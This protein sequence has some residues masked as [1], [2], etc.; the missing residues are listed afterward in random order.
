[1]R[2]HK[3]VIICIL[4]I[5]NVAFAQK[6]NIDFYPQITKYDLAKIWMPE[7]VI[8]DERTREKYSHNLVS[9]NLKNYQKRICQLL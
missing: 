3:I 4:F 8:H 7:S 5:I 1:M 6:D 2:F 9:L